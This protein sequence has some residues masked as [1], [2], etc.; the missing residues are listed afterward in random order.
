MFGDHVTRTA[1]NLVSDRVDS[2][3]LAGIIQNKVLAR[4]DTGG[5]WHF[6]DPRL[7]GDAARRPRHHHR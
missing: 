4:L 1:A 6:W 5:T 3:L 2:C 7:S